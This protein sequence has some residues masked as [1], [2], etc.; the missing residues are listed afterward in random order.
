MINLKISKKIL[1]PLIILVILILIYA[2]R[3]QT[4]AQK[5]NDYRVM[6]WQKNIITGET[7]LKEYR[8]SEIKTK[9]LERDTDYSFIYNIIVIGNAGYLII[10][11]WKIKRVPK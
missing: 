11:L 9:K 8:S 4:L 6:K 3:W 10:Q 2:F 5:T 1:I 7:I